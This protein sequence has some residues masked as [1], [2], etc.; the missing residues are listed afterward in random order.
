M[1]TSPASNAPQDALPSEKEPVAPLEAERK[2]EADLEK[3]VDRIQKTAEKQLASVHG[4]NVSLVKK[5]RKSEAQSAALLN[6]NKDLEDK[7]ND[8]VA[9]L[10]IALMENHG[11]SVKADQLDESE[12]RYQEKTTAVVAAE[13]ALKNVDV[14]LKKA[15]ANLDSVRSERD[16]LEMEV[17]S[18]R[19]DIDQLQL[20]LDDANDAVNK[21][22]EL[23]K[24]DVEERS[25]QIS[26]LSQEKEK[27]QQSREEL[28]SQLRDFDAKLAA[29][30]AGLNT[31][32]LERDAA[33]KEAEIVR[34]EAERRLAELKADA[35]DAI[36]VRDTLVKERDDALEK[37]ILLEQT[38]TD[39]TNEKNILADA[40]ELRDRE[41]K[42]VK[43]E[44]AELERASDTLQINLDNK[45]QELTGL[46]GQVS[47]LRS[48][49]KQ[50]EVKCDELQLLLD[51]KEKE[52][53]LVK[54]DLK[55][56]NETLNQIEGERNLLH[57][58]K[59]TLTRDFD[60]A[61]NKSSTL[62]RER[63]ELEKRVYDLEEMKKGLEL[64]VHTLK[65][66]QEDSEALYEKKL[67]EKIAEKEMEFEAQIVELRK[68]LEAVVDRHAESHR[69]ETRR[70][71]AAAAAVAST[72]PIVSPAPIDSSARG[73]P[74]DVDLIEPVEDT[75]MPAPTVPVEDTSRAIE[76]EETVITF[77]NSKEVETE[78][79]GS[80][81][82]NDKP[83]EAA[84]ATAAP[85][86]PIVAP[87]PFD[88]S[89]RAFPKDVDVI[90]PVD[91]APMPTPT[92][93]VDDTSRAIEP[94]D[95]EIVFEKPE[96]VETEDIGATHDNDWKNLEVPT[97]IPAAPLPYQGPAEDSDEDVDVGDGTAVMT[98]TIEEDDEDEEDEEDE[99]IDNGADSA[100]G[101][102]D[103]RNMVVSEEVVD[104]VVVDTP[105]KSDDVAP[106]E[107]TMPLS[108]ENTEVTPV[109][110]DVKDVPVQDVTTADAPIVDNPLKNTETIEVDVKPVSTEKAIETP[111]VVSPVATTDRAAK[112]MVPPKA[113][114]KA[115]GNPFLCCMGSS[116]KD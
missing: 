42:R 112:E 53:E 69:I 84:P 20:K 16:A 8:L 7:N 74:K 67:H 89:A 3:E 35:D 58:E 26:A 80:T 21:E 46:A 87:T 71:E 47:Q 51:E 111:A 107:T 86:V 11:L 64:A 77:E 1:P 15:E 17:S 44:L 68:E 57:S 99:F 95:T 97:E 110:I 25:F 30:T 41:L 114:S 31:T 2:E 22:R 115:R 43:D 24:S 6:A 13:L 33:L 9:K 109:E 23:R 27:E 65:L 32:L 54:S 28:E 63:A 88:S 83:E 100:E 45:T 50:L 98:R 92:V 62:E 70:E 34:E 104:E 39:V 10:K 18:L 79:F 19:S 106:G 59:S 81:H 5:I 40:V 113:S 116:E 103:P 93:P 49:H 66:Q 101:E 48:D 56:R 94:E 12:K 38:V 76:L 37:K 36:N 85:T 90:E 82:D 61:R 60:E 75:P 73:L 4:L 96:E 55:I 105:T 29:A 78:D 14:A 102:T 72:V 108:S 52:A 91:D